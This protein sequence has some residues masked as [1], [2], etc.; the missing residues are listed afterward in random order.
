MVAAASDWTTLG[1]IPVTRLT[2]AL[3]TVR[4]AAEAMI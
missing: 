1:P 3:P 2:T 4:T